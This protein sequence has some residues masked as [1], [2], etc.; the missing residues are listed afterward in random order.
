M[1][2]FGQ[3]PHL[4]S[5]RGLRRLLFRIRSRP[6][7]RNLGDAGSRQTGRYPETGLEEI[8]RDFPEEDFGATSSES[9]LKR[10]FR[11]ARDSGTIV[12]LS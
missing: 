2:T 7:E 3:I 5:C 1:Q 11:L 8:N 4:P 12:K 6:G 10:N 9:A